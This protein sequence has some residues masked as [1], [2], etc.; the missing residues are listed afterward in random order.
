[1]HDNAHPHV[2]HRVQ[3]QINVTEWVAL[4][5]PAYGPDLSAQ[6][7]HVFGTLKKVLKGIHIGS[8]CASG[9]GTVV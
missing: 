7:F 8:Q 1:V 5:H 4:K 2:A 3:V 6:D 9:C